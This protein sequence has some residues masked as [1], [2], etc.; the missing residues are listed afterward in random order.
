MQIHFLKR[1]PRWKINTNERHFLERR[2]WKRVHVSVQPLKSLWHKAGPHPTIRQPLTRAKAWWAFILCKLCIICCRVKQLQMSSSSLSSRKTSD[3]NVRDENKSENVSHCLTK[4]ESTSV[5]GQDT[6]TQDALS[7]SVQEPWVAA[8]RP[9]FPLWSSSP[10]EPAV[11][12]ADD[13]QVSPQS[14]LSSSSVLSLI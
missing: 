10:V 11:E 4:N 8:G 12:P 6:E 5:L 13:A 7:G 1:T 14:F 2:V 3:L 9:S